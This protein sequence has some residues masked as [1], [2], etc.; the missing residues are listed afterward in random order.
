MAITDDDIE[1]ALDWMVKN[2]EKA[3]KA[4]ATRVLIEECLKPLKAK[5]MKQSKADSI[6][7]Q[8]R[9]A[10]ASQEYDDQLVGLEAAV[11]VDE[12]FR[13]RY[14]SAEARIEAWRTMSSNNR[15]IGK[16]T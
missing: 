16:V 10:L 13:L 8:E 11:Y 9:D 7:A 2:S 14:K 3:A 12:L 5:L 1:R 6:G 15:S 4:R